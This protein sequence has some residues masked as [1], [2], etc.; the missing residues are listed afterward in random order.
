MG[1]TLSLFSLDMKTARDFGLGPEFVPSADGEELLGCQGLDKAWHVVH[2]L[3]T[4][5]AGPTS[6]PLGLLYAAGV[7][8]DDV[9]EHVAVVS[10]DQVRVFRDALRDV[11]DDE[12]R[13]RFDLETMVA[14]D[15]Y[16]AD[17]LVDEDWDY[18]SQGIPE[19]RDFSEA[20]TGRGCGAIVVI[21]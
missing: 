10:A 4:G 15:V 21:C 2:F 7:R 8:L 9:S 6:D 13:L 16:R 17:L 19:L 20:C 5:T 11:S 3:L 18:V 12:L 14:A 1:M